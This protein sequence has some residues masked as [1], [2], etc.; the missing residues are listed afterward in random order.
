VQDT[1]KNI[2]STNSCQTKTQLALDLQDQ[3][4]T[5]IL[6]QSENIVL[7]RGPNYG[8][9][10]AFGTT[11][12]FIADPI[13]PV[14]TLAQLYMLENWAKENNY[15]DF[16]SFAT[17]TQRDVQ[18]AV[19]LKLKD[20]G[21]KAANLTR[22]NKQKIKLMRK[23]VRGEL[24]K[25]AE[26]CMKA[27]YTIFTQ[28]HTADS[29]K[30]FFMLVGKAGFSKSFLNSLA[31]ARA[32]QMKLPITVISSPTIH[33]HSNL[34]LFG[35][36]SVNTAGTFII[37]EF[38]GDKTTSKPYFNKLYNHINSFSTDIPRIFVVDPHEFQFNAPKEGSAD[39]FLQSFE[40]VFRTLASHLSKSLFF[41]AHSCPL[42]ENLTEKERDV[43]IWDIRPDLT[44]LN[45][46][47]THKTLH[48]AMEKIFNQTKASTDEV[49]ALARE[50]MLS[51]L[52]LIA[53]PTLRSYIRCMDDAPYVQRFLDENRVVNFDPKTMR[54]SGLV[55]YLPKS[56]PDNVP[57]IAVPKFLRESFPHDFDPDVDQDVK[58][59][60]GIQKTYVSPYLAAH[61]VITETNHLI[62]AF[63]GDTDEEHAIFKTA[64]LM[65]NHQLPI[66]WPGLGVKLQNQGDSIP[67]TAVS[68]A[69]D[70]GDLLT[71]AQELM[72]PPIK[73]KYLDTPN[74]KNPQLF[75]NQITS[76]HHM[77]LHGIPTVP[78]H[79]THAIDNC[80]ATDFLLP[81]HD[82]SNKLRLLFIQ[83][84]GR[85]GS[86]ADKY[87]VGSN[88]AAQLLECV[89]RHK[90]SPNN[91]IVEGHDYI[92][93]SPL[94]TPAMTKEVPYLVMETG[95]PTVKR[96]YYGT[97]L[98]LL[99]LDK[100][101]LLKALTLPS[102]QNH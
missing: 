19:D 30:N 69:K 99:G 9:S 55:Q 92:I 50:R 65:V 53:A 6:E 75:S 94:K 56:I 5:E 72:F 4:P 70:P 26:A 54:K 64:Q 28:H 34:L 25:N 15:K 27:A 98:E 38:Y 2:T 41:S 31:V 29:K 100:T 49:T 82:K 48:S 13:R 21:T 77:S 85:T 61:R 22:G 51:Y 93:Y 52:H 101:S 71:P 33:T 8:E 87:R 78:G 36:F 59:V 10:T 86:V 74:A 16:T 44:F 3:F 67:I 81:Y 96:V 37:D 66:K 18:Q 83:I 102:P 63:R 62:P 84:T 39:Q 89:N 42:V 11:D 47:F 46:S 32:I 1:A 90:I 80:P 17:P 57:S 76:R 45:M 23:A 20:L 79:L 24:T 58:Q 43:P 12:Y 73:A 88:T 68:P 91:T 7:G 97:P 14:V 35:S 60:G 40:R 95:N